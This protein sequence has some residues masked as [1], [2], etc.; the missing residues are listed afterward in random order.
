MI[1]AYGS[2]LSTGRQIDS[3]FVA[4]STNF[5]S[6]PRRFFTA[7]ELITSNPYL[8]LMIARDAQ[9]VHNIEDEC[10]LVADYTA[11]E[12]LPL[13]RLYCYRYGE[14][15]APS[16][17]A[18]LAQQP[19]DARTSTAAELLRQLCKPER[20]ASIMQWTQQLTEALAPSS[21][22]ADGRLKNTAVKKTFVLYRATGGCVICGT[23]ATGNVSSTTYEPACALYIAHT[24]KEHQELAS[25]FPSV[26][27]FVHS[28]LQLQLDL[29]TVFK[30]NSVPESLIEPLC[31]IIAHEIECTPLPPARKGDQFTLT[32]TRKSGFRLLL[33]L[34][35][36]LN[37]AYLIF[38][39]D[40]TQ[41]KRIDSAPDHPHLPCF[42]DHLHLAPIEDNAN[43]VS[44]FTYGF[45]LLDLPLIARLLS[46]AE[47]GYAK[48]PE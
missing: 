9:V 30:S 36:L 35:T 42:P 21:M 15:P 22:L 6:I 46:E 37:Y 2:T 34:R 7:F 44:S 25:K 29:G 38:S 16:K 32:F 12:H 19:I 31:E 14:S 10:L 17:E 11:V 26:L 20:V 13:S 24:C 3:F 8:W 1:E 5:L 45:P 33:R 23:G 48:S 27:H 28:L 40:G 18:L 43:V 47:T 4:Q 39:P 41:L